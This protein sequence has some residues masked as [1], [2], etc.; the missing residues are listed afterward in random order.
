MRIIGGRFR[1]RPLLSVRGQKTRPTADRLRETLFNILGPRVREAAVLDLFAGTGALGLEAL[2]RGAAFAAFVEIDRAALSVIQKNIDRCGLSD[3][4]A[5]VR[6]NA[7][8][9]LTPLTGLGRQFDLIFLDPP[10][11]KALAPP[12]L[13]ALLRGDLLTDNARLVVE[14]APG[15]PVLPPSPDPHPAPRNPQLTDP[16]PAFTLTDRRKYGK[17]EISFLEV[18]G[19][20]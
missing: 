5:T 7:A 1:G 9:H 6:C 15:D 8:A 4:A 13:T 18:R 19:N 14:H 20:R 11:G 10:Y 3:R 16:H 2:S 12:A 17:T